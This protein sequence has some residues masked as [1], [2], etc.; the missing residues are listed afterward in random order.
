MY[1]SAVSLFYFLSFF[2]NSILHCAI[3]IFNGNKRAFS[4][5]FGFYADCN[6][7]YIVI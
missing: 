4:V 3:H 2:Y 5:N 1:F 6:S 7:D